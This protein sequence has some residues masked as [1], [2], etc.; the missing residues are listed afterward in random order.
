MQCNKNFKITIF[1]YHTVGAIQSEEQNCVCTFTQE[2][3]IVGIT[4]VLFALINVTVKNVY[5][6][7]YLKEE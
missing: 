5:I 4:S 3:K 7:Y 6:K 2:I 1:K